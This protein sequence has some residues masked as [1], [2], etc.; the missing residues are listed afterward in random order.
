[1]KKLMMFILTLA[2]ASSAYAQPKQAQQPPEVRVAMQP[3]AWDTDPDRAAFINHRSV[4]AVQGLDNGALM[5]L[6]TLDFTDGTIEFDIEL[7]ERGFVGIQFRQ[8]DDHSVGEDFYIPLLLAREPA[9]SH[10]HAIHDDGG[11]PELVG[12]HRRLPSPRPAASKQVEPREAGRQRTAD[13]GIR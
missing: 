12:P 2:I 13:A 6:K 11:Q 10:P 1:M 9:Q 4:P 3:D 5:H 7:P 8:S